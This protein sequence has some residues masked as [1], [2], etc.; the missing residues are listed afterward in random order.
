MNGKKKWTMNQITL[1]IGIPLGL[2]FLYFAFTSKPK[3]VV[4]PPK[5]VEF[6]IGGQKEDKAAKKWTV[7]LL[8]TTENA[9]KVT[10]EPLIGKVEPTGNTSVTLEKS[11]TFV[12]SA[13]NERGKAEFSLEIEL[14]AQ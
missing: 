5:V 6:R 13:T 1:A 2:V 4:L 12:L 10:I 7:D 8:W 14:P 3:P 11:G 9:E